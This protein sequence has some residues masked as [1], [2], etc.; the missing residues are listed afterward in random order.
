MFPLAT[1]N[2]EYPG[3]V[4]PL[5]LSL[6]IH[7]PF[8]AYRCRYCNFT[9]ET[10]WSEPLMSRTLD[11]IVREAEG[12][13]ERGERDGLDWKVRTLYLG[14]GTPGV[15]PAE[16][17]VPFLKKLETVLGYRTA[18]LAE[19]SL[20]ANPENLTPENLDAWDRAGIRR[21][22][23]GIQTFDSARLALL[24]RWC[25]GPTNR[26]ALGLAADRWKGRWSADLMSG[27]PGQGDLAPQRWV[28]LRADLRELLDYGPG[29]VSL[30]S[31]TVEPETDLATLRAGGGLRVAE[32]P[33]ADQLWLRARQTLIDAGYEWYE[34]SNFALPGHRS[35]HNQAYWRMDPWAGL[36]PGAEGTLP[37]RDDSGALRPYRTKNPRLFP[38]LTGGGTSEIVSAPEFALEHYLAGWRTSDGLVPGRFAATF[39]GSAPAVPHRLNDQERLTLNRFLAT[40]GGLENLSYRGD[41]SPK[42]GPES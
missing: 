28:D 5:P 15:V 41:W 30:Y 39:T 25:D 8:C 22:S 24:G 31:L 38:W 40:L 7:I 12:L 34:I 21:L 11:A 9:F 20:E 33:V 4:I 27:L 16:L 26:R 17:L 35:I 3:A 10:G 18:S 42:V 19:A 14:G 37:A 23:L 36:G 6:Y 32:D 13:R 2:K 29:H 1:K